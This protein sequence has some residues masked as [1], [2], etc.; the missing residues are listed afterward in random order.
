MTRSWW[1]TVLH[2]C[3]WT[4]EVTTAKYVL[5][6]PSSEHTAKKYDQPYWNHVAKKR[7]PSPAEADECLKAGVRYSYKTNGVNILYTWTWK[8]VRAHLQIH[9][10]YRNSMSIKCTVKCCFSRFQLL[11]ITR[12]QQAPEMYQ[13]LDS[14]LIS[15]SASPPWFE[16]QTRFTYR[17]LKI[18]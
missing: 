10:Y 12:T 7:L 1:S 16:A 6:K 2:V 15:S 14:K 8:L 5:H 9:D 4:P 18:D 3:E 11:L 13:L 17:C